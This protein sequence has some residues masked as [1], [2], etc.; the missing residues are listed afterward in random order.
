MYLCVLCGSENKQI[1]F[2]Y[3]ALTDW[4][5]NRDSVCLLRGTK[6][7]FTYHPSSQCHVSGSHWPVSHRVIPILIPDPVKM[8]F[9]LNKKAL[10]HLFVRLILFLPYQYHPTIAAYPYS[11]ICCSYHKD[12]WE[13]LWN[14]PKSN[15]LSSITKLCLGCSC[16]LFFKLWGPVAGSF[17]KFCAICLNNC[18]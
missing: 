5:Y 1:L 3:T 8:V 17:D 7:A 2:P 15:A 4:F 12:N 6:Q 13:Q 18:R 9:L 10:W 16:H 11:L 14:L